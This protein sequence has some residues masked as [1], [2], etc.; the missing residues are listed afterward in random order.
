MFTYPQIFYRPRAPPLFDFESIQKFKNRTEKLKVIKTDITKLSR[1]QIIEHFERERQEWLSAGMNE[2]DIFRIHFGELS[3]DGRSG[4][5]RMWLN[6]R[7]HIRPDHKYAP[8]MPVAID[9]VDPDGTWISGGYGGLD[10]AEFAIDLETALSTLT[11]L[12]RFCFVEVMLSDRTQQSI[13]DELG[14]KQQVVDKHI[15]AAKKKLKIFFK[16]SG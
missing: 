1:K 6:E 8:G 7:K 14:I 16:E 12:Q 9:A 3:D 13:A 4:D 2:A 11:E 5:Y 15:R 10:N